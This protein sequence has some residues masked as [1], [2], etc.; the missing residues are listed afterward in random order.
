[1]YLKQMFLAQLE[2]ESAATRKTLERVPERHNDWK[3]HEK[4]MTLGYLAGLVASMP[5]WAEFMIERDE[6]DL[7]DPSADRFKA[8]AVE[9]QNRVAQN[10]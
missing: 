2:R 3:P 4:S 7:N 5:A 6:L 9:S 1:M 10:A 8:R